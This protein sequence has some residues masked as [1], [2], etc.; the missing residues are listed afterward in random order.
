M[1]LTKRQKIIFNIVAVICIAI[2]AFAVSPKTLQNDTYYTVKIGEH[3]LNTKTVDMMDPFSWHQD[4]KYTYPHWLYDVMMNIIYQI[5]SWDGIYI[6]TIVFSSLLGIAI[7]FTN[8]KLTKNKLTSL[9]FAL[10]DLYLLKDFIAARAQ[11]VTFI[12][13]ALTIYLLERFVVKPKKIYAIC[14]VIISLL[15]ANLHCA[16][17][18]FF[19]IL[20]LPYIAEYLFIA[21]YD[22]DIMLRVIY[23]IKKIKIKLSKQNNKEE[24]IKIEKQEL[25]RKLKAIKE[26][27]SLARKNAY[28]IE[29]EKNKNI[30]YLIIVAII[31]ALMGLLTPL[32]DTP[33]T[34]LIKTM[35]G[36]TT[37][38]INEHLPITF[39]DNKP[40]LIVY[41]VL[42][43][44]WMFTKT[45]IKLRDLF[46]IGGL[47]LLT[48]MSKRQSSMLLV[49]GTLIFNKYLAKYLETT[50][51]KKLQQNITKTV[52]TIIG[53]ILVISIV[54][55]IG[56]NLYKDKKDDKYISE[57]TYPVQACDFILNNIEDLK[58]ARFFNEYNYGSY[59]LYRNIPVFID[60]RAD[61]YAPEFS[62]K[63]EDIFSD[64]LDISN[65]S[66]DYEDNFKKYGITHVILYQDA[67][68]NNSLKLDKNYKQI[69][70]DKHFV[71][72]ERLK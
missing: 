13:F 34:Y 28:K 15:I 40:I 54:G 8:S 12:L 27:R 38:N 11:L 43:A 51:L 50:T 2:M 33:Y 62:G 6:S 18:P 57:S 35:Q 19:F 72:Y 10:L 24:L 25:E 53:A 64:F 48:I 69:Y 9:I 41:A 39:W 49:V 7:Y 61:L 23:L 70:S 52:G 42:I 66:M 68:L 46:L 14:L 55:L 59:M 47:M 30:K 20:F 3:I 67:K 16:V 71:I 63:D 56:Y 21:Y 29:I 36:N 44:L 5:G 37:Q 1:E 4:L 65:F 22:S 26:Q 31:C 60:S 45:K 17:W 32:G 58:N